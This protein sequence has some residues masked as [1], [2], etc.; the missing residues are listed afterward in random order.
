NNSQYPLSKTVSSFA[1]DT[2]G[3]LTSSTVTQSDTANAAKKLVTT[4]AN[5]FNS[6]TI[7]QRYGRLTSS[8]VSKTLDGN[9]ATT[10]TR[11]SAFTYNADL[12]LDT[13]TLSPNAVATKVATK[14]LYDAAG[15][16]TGKQV[17]AATTAIGTS[18][19]T[20]SSS[21]AY[22]SRYR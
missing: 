4:T 12:M 16:L 3:N 2:Y 5:V 7:Y 22:D 1:Y 20:R 6:S 10:I 14:H 13:E 19:V 18:N 8:T 21:T 15:N 17:T 11:Q 9:A